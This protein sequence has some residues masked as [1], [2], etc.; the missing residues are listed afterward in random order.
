M[1][2]HFRILHEQLNIYTYDKIVS[3]VQIYY[4][5]FSYNSETPDL[6]LSSWSIYALWAVVKETP[7]FLIFNIQ[8]YYSSDMNLFVNWLFICILS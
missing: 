7:T 3:Y 6:N 8:Y 2:T 1:R 4:C 5:I